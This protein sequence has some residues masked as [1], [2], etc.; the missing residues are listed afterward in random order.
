MKKIYSLLTSLLLGLNIMAQAPQSFNYQ[1][2]VRNS[3]GTIIANTQVGIKISILKGSASG[4]AVCLEEFTPTTNDFGLVTLAI[5]SI[6]TSDFEAIDWSAGSYFVKVELDPAGGTDYTEMGISQ[7]ISVPY[8]LHAKKAETLTGTIAGVDQL[9]SRLTAME[10]MLIDAGL[11]TLSDLDGN[12]YDYVKIGTQIWMAENL[13]TTKFNDGDAIPLVTGIT[14]WSN[15]YMTPAY[16]WYANDSVSYAQTYGA[17]Y[18]QETIIAGG[19]C[20]AGWHIPTDYEW[21]KLEMAVGMSQTEADA[22]G[23][24]RG[25]NE[26]SKLAGNDDLWNKDTLKNDAEFGSSGFNALPGG[27][28]GEDGSFGTI[29][30]RGHWWTATEISKNWLYFRGIGEGDNVPDTRGIYRGDIPRAFGFSVR[31]VRDDKESVVIDYDGNIYSTVTIGTQTWMAE[32]LKTTH[33]ADGTALTD[34]KG[35]G[36]LSADDTK[37]YWFVHGDMMENKAYYGL[38]Y[39]WRAAMNGAA[40]SSANPSRIQGVCPDGWHLPSQ[41]EWIEL[42]NYL[43]ANGYNFDG[44]TTDN[45]IAKALATGCTGWTS[46][47]FLDAIG[48]CEFPGKMNVT[49]FSGRPGGERGSD[50]L[51]NLEHLW[52][53]WWSST[54]HDETY[55]LGT[56]LHYSWYALEEVNNFSYNNGVSVRCV[57]D[58]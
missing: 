19:L 9:E 58:K 43:I 7:L 8:A 30:S 10:D 22:Y 13:R 28:R 11:Y 25:T 31:C 41:A 24:F 29:G 51:Y 16:S 3:Y 26:G 37:K 14:E 17:L 38:L 55:V 34:G 40:S 35:V 21:K 48:N 6:N 49:G 27:A 44:S 54:A 5:G 33:Y 32:N 47:A 42:E 53:R 20:P 50:G 1:A 15:T 36:E 2:V 12:T 52:G 39:T 18:N 46:S 57:M 4:T 45:K 23:K 56:G